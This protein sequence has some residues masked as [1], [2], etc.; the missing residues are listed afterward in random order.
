[1]NRVDSINFDVD[2]AERKK[3]E[4]VLMVTALKN[5]KEK[6]IRTLDALDMEI[7]GIKSMSL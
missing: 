2:P 7:V 4:E 1:M 6:A 3:Q 5:A